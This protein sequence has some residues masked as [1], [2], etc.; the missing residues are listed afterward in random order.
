[1]NVSHE[2]DKTACINASRAA[3]KDADASSSTDSSTERR[4]R[5]LLVDDEESIISALRRL[6]KRENYEFLTANCGEKALQLQEQNPAQLIISDYRMPAMTGIELLRQIRSRWPDTVRI[7]LSGYSQVSAIIAAINE[8]AIYKFISKPWN[9]EE[10]KLHIRRA[11]EQYQLS[12]ENKQMAREIIEQNKKLQE[13]NERLKQ[14]AVDAC[15]GLTST[16]DIL[17][18]I[19]VGVL[20][21]D[22]SGL[23]VGA[24]WHA[25]EIIA[26]GKTELMGIPAQAAL[27]KILYDCACAA[28]AGNE[29]ASGQLEHQGR[30]LQFRASPLKADDVC[31]GGVLA[32]WEEVA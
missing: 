12:A 30:R 11:L 16:Q 9:D 32:I 26:S 17:E 13:L 31:R 25:Y 14:R 28:A 10:L 24:N 6:L 7:I 3:L 18:T 19:G 8:G 22:S 1:M 27:P 2:T 21:I 20:T 23:I 29:G 5:I 15:R 4:Y